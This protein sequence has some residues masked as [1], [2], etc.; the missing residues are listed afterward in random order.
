MTQGSIPFLAHLDEL[1]SR[2]IKSIAL[3]VLA[4]FLFY[5]FVPQVMR[6]FI[7][8]VGEVVFTSPAEAFFVHV[9]VAL[10]GGLCLAMPFVLYQIWQFV[11]LGLTREE[12][13][14][15]LFLAPLSFILFAAGVAFAYF[16]ILPVAMKFFLSFASDMIKP[17]I[18]MSKYIAFIGMFLLSFG[19]AF[20]LPLAIIFLTKIGIVTPRFLIEK[21]KYAIVVI[22]VVSAILTPSP[23]VVSQLLMAGPL[24]VLYETG[25]IFSKIIGQPGIKRK[26]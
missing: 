26:G 15:I 10:I 14:I 1:R 23:D 8:P 3:I 24:I 17:M 4:S 2:L 25:I 13:S 19:F 18:S 22:F 16:F 5:P 9:N 21:R 6:F 20:E 12:K 7:L 11:A